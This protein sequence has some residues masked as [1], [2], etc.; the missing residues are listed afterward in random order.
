MRWA[1]DIIKHGGIIFLANG[2]GSIFNMLYQLYMVRNL[3]PVD[4]G[5]LNSLLAL[6]LIVSVPAGTLQTAIT[7]Y[8]AGFHAFNQLTKIRVFLLRF[9]KEILIFSTI[10]FLIILICSRHISNF[11]QISTITPVILV[12]V[13]ILFSIVHPLTMGGL[14]GLQMFGWLGI[15]GVMG[16]ALRLIF[17]ILLVNLGL[18]VLGAL[19][20]IIIANFSILILS[21]IPLRRYL[22]PSYNDNVNYIDEKINFLDVYKYFIPVAITFFCFMTLI[23]VDVILVKHFFT[24]LEAGCYSVAQMVGKIIFFLPTAI[25]IVMFPKTSNLYSIG[26]DTIPILKKCLSIVVSLCG[27]S[28]LG[29][30]LFPSLIINILSGRPH[31][32]CIPLAKLFA[33]AMTFYAITYILLFYQLSIKYLKFVYPLVFFT[34]LQIILIIIFHNNLLQVLY[35][36]CTTAILLC[37]VNIKLAFTKNL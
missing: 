33:I 30:F 14:Q 3:N 27:I 25:V 10:A 32:E 11:F 28:T 23:G 16:A 26:K 36:L 24:P 31:I 8:T 21:L 9:T 4:Y 7:N 29:I 35:I 20:A 5:I 37:I 18:K 22:T 1:D 15:S 34:A 17:G 19:G 6:L 2:L 12:G 13:L